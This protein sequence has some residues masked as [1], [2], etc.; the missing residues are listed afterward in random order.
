MV[1]P[2][3][4]THAA[5]YPENEYQ[6]SERKACQV[7]VLNRNTK[8]RIQRDEPIDDVVFKVI[9]L[10]VAQSRWGYRKVYD[11]LKLDGVRVGRERV[12]VIRKREGVHGEFIPHLKMS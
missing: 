3:D 2:S 12:R 7:L 4:K 9:E 11:R 10:S 8:R 1:T 5:G 6:V